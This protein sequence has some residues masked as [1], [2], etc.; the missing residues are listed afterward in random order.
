MKADKGQLEILRMLREFTAGEQLSYSCLDSTTFVEGKQSLLN[1]TLRAKQST[2]R[3]SHEG[4]TF[5]VDQVVYRLLIHLRIA[6]DA[7]RSLAGNQL[8][9]EPTKEDNRKW[10]DANC[11]FNAA[12][13]FACAALDAIAHLKWILENPRGVGSG[14]KHAESKWNEQTWEFERNGRPWWDGIKYN[15]DNDTLLSQD[16]PLL[17]SYVIEHFRNKPIHRNYDYIVIL[18]DSE[19]HRRDWAIVKPELDSRTLA[20]IRRD[21][22]AGWDREKTGNYLC[23]S[24]SYPITPRQFVRE[25]LAF[26]FR[27]TEEVL[28]V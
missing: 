26:A 3:F 8:S 7:Y 21:A 17:V 16:T 23:D 1:Q 14:Q 18:S 10:V 20:E 27:E 5:H 19:H 11:S 2:H 24:K 12:V 28:N 4:L 6:C 13:V 15:G 9:S 22:K 25:L